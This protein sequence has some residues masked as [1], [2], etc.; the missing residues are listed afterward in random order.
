[1]TGEM[2]SPQREVLNSQR[3]HW[4]STYTN[5]PEMF[6]ESPSDPAQKALALLKQEGKTKLIELGGGQG[7]DTF[8]F[9]RN[10]IKD[11]VI[12]YSQVA[13]DT[14]QRKARASGLAE[15][16]TALQH[17]VR[18]SLP[19]EDNSFDACYSHMLFCMPLT[20]E[21]LGRLSS[22][23]R[24]VLKPGGLNV[25]TVRHTGDPHYG[26]GIHRGED[27]YEVGGFVVH[28]FDRAKVEL[29]AKG[30]EVVSIDEFEEGGLPRKL[31]RVT[32]R[33]N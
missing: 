23:V 17:D 19:F 26:T 20:S 2:K 31:F 8:F 24:R 12:D 22:E 1:M 4:E 32:L 5:K 29:L 10:G 27:M 3:E 16:I 6:G 15:S 18:V 30:Y 7:R 11:T 28:F 9:A 25:Y 21:E 33:K 14:I 13:V